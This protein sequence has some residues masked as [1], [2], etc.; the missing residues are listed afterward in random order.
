MLDRSD[1]GLISRIWKEFLKL[2]KQDN[3]MKKWAKGL[4]I[5]YSREDINM[6]ISTRKDAQHNEPLEK[7]KSKQTTMRLTLHT[8]SD[9]R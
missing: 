2:N 8:H 5:H 1:K 3:P 9:G 7:Y 6:A 4:K